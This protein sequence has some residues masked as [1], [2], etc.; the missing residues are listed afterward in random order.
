LW[1]FTEETDKRA[2]QFKARLR[3]LPDSL[4]V[5]EEWRKLLVDYG[6]SGVQVHDT[7]PIAAM[8]VHGVKRIL[9]FNPL[10][11]ARFTRIE[12]VNSEEVVRQN[13]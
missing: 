2:R 5:H 1:A 13:R 11:F 10:D 3:L 9:T 6:V 4:A 7:R 12:A 8:R